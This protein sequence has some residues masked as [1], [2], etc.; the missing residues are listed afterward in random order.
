MNRASLTRLRVRRS[1]WRSLSAAGPVMRKAFL[2]LL[3]ASSVRVYGGGGD[4]GD[5]GGDESTQTNASAS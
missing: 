2:W 3:I 5:D 1:Q 4:M